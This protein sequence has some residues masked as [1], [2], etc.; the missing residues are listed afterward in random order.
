MA[1]PGET[2]EKKRLQKN[3]GRNMLFTF[4]ATKRHILLDDEAKLNLCA[5]KHPPPFF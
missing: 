4:K 2:E 5:R 1:M 3:I